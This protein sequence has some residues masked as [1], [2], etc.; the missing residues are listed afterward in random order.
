MLM[1]LWYDPGGGS[2]MLGGESQFIH[3]SPGRTTRHAGWRFDTI[4]LSF[5]SPWTIGTEHKL[6]LRHGMLRGR[7][8][9]TR[10]VR[11]IIHS[12]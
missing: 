2:G 3:S 10:R 11:E 9:Q 8:G 1:T 6:D 4:F 7:Q 5:N 12:C